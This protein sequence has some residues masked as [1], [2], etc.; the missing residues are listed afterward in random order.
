VLDVQH[1]PS[2][3]CIF[4]IGS[5]TKL[6]YCNKVLHAVPDALGD[7]TNLRVL[8][9][10]CSYY[11]T[12]PAT[13]GQ[14]TRLQSLPVRACVRLRTLPI[15]LGLLSSLLSLNI[16]YCSKLVTL[17]DSLSCLSNLQELNDM[18]CEMLVAPL[19]LPPGCI[20]SLS[21]HGAWW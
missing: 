21:P 11:E 8:D 17:P 15:T 13:V 16:S 14:L 19:H 3:Q 7:L 20:R 18:G 1:L 9:L 5:L 2:S 10:G 6:T 12:L 4:R